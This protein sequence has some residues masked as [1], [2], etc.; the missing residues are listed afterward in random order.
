[1]ERKRLLIVAFGSLL[2][3][4]LSLGGYTFAWMQYQKTLSNDIAIAAGSLNIKSFS[5]K[6]YK[7]F[8]PDYLGSYESEGQLI[9]YDGV[10]AV[11]P[12]PN[13]GYAMNVL[14]PSY[15]TIHPSATISD[16][17]TNLVIRV[18]FSLE[19]S[20]PLTLDFSV[21]TKTVTLGE[22]QFA[23]SQFLHYS[24]LTPTASASYGGLGD[25]G[26]FT[27]VKA[28]AE[29]TVNH[30]VS[31][32]NGASSLNLFGSEGTDLVG[33]YDPAHVSPQTFYFFVNV[34]YDR[35]LCDRFFD[36]SRLGNDYSLVPDY[37]FELAVRQ[38]V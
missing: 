23:A 19:Y 14:D 33:T 8:F 12:S 6:P 36:P 30:P 34:D 3:V 28:Y 18:D 4:S 1:M 37:S 2:L 17:E 29:D 5:L 11:N 15:L 16:L 10:T 31:I 22:N 20:T 25:T 38:K 24:A 13:R 27:G 35:T 9:N 21:K 32:L 7:L 26:I